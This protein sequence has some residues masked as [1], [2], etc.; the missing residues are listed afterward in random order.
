MRYL[1]AATGALVIAVS[2][3]AVAT[4][5]HKSSHAHA[6]AAAKADKAKMAMPN[7]GAIFALF[8]KMFPPQADPDPARLAIAQSAVGAMWP[9]GSY[10]KMMTGMLGGAVDHAMAL[11][12][13]DLAAISGKEADSA[14][15][16]GALSLHDLAAAKDP[17]FDERMTAI[18]T[19]VDEE[20]GKV[21]V[22]IDPRIREGLAR[23]MA[24][25]FDQAQ[26]TDINAFF[27][28]P[29]GHAFA[30]QYM[31]LWMSPDTMRSIFT[32]MP[33]LMKLMPEMM[34]KVKAASDQF[35]DIKKAAA[36]TDKP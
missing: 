1:I 4:T 31:Q 28:T 21:S 13:S 19:A 5:A 30:G 2:A 14:G 3:P 12:M 24:R 8:D 6:S 27:A 15:V 9:D 18:R 32:S 22:V 29:T 11:K 36:K 23:T 20:M 35:P 34:E 33:E 7:I 17:H 16:A 25:R 26:L 10:G